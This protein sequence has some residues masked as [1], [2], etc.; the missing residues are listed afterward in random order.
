MIM[1]GK[2]Y[3]E[4]K[5]VDLKS[6]QM[7]LETAELQLQTIEAMNTFLRITGYDMNKTGEVVR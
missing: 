5:E 6:D 2:Y 7:S 3:V 4:G 1:F